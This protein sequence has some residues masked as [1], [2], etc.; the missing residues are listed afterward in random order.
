MIC[1]ANC[2]SPHPPRC[3]ELFVNAPH[4]SISYIWQV[5]GCQHTLEPTDNDFE[6]P[7]I[8]ALTLKGFVRWESI[9]I[10]LAPEE[11]VPFVR[12]AVKNWHLKNLDTDEVFP[13]DIPATAF[14]SEPDPEITAW[15]A[16]CGDKLKKEATPKDSPRPTFA[17]AADR[18]SAGFSHVPAFA[19]AGGASRPQR[20]TGLGSDYFTHTHRSVPFAHV[21]PGHASGQY[22]RGGPSL[23][24]SPERGERVRHNT[25]SSP[26]E[27]ARRRSFSD[28]PSPNEPPLS[29]HL[30]APRPSTFRR[31]SHPRRFSEDESQSDND[32]SPH[33]SRRSSGHYGSSHRSPK[34]VPHVAHVAVPAKGPPGGTSPA[35]PSPPTV[36]IPNVRTEGGAKLRSDDRASPVTSARRKSAPFEGAKDWA[37]D[38]IDR[39]SG[40]FPGPTPGDRPRR[41][42]GSN[43]NISSGNLPVDR[44]RDSL[45]G[46][47]SRLHHNLSYDEND[48]DSEDER[49]R[50]QQRRRIR[51]RERERDRRDRDR[52]AVYERERDRLPRRSRDTPDWDDELSRDRARSRKEK[53]GASARYLRRPDNPRRTSSHA[54]VDRMDRDRHRIYD[55][56]VRD[57]DRYV[58]ERRRRGGPLDDRDRERGA[59]PVIKGVGGR[60]YP[61]EPTWAPESP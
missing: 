38:K 45:H 35:V 14:P 1:Y 37:K 29:A 31:H 24:V 4:E 43:G 59:S 3:T 11:H 34:V 16:A 49:E 6:Q 28:Y 47:S 40:I 10:L 36:Q 15:H 32:A 8:P 7:S 61:A 55:G 51:E 44:S 41:S 18:V 20:P 27:R 22:T 21:S 12:Y 23:R 13:R 60:R 57:R 17:S 2:G 50:R 58:D 54:D 26:D 56:D 48:T 33:M 30:H 53:D 5:F 46:S 9:Q 42:P 52:D 39:F 19:D 25:H